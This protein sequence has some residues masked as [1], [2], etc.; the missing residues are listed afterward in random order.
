MPP[1]QRPSGLY[2]R[3]FIKCAGSPSNPFRAEP[4]CLGQHASGVCPKQPDLVWNRR[5]RRAGALDEE[6]RHN[7]SIG[8]RR[9]ASIHPPGWI[10]SRGKSWHELK[11]E[12]L[13][14]NTSTAWTRVVVI[15]T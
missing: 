8:M 6:V 13:W 2:L 14:T 12:E 15:S 10:F 9:G 7:D 4:G 3:H 1:A 5:T 11:V